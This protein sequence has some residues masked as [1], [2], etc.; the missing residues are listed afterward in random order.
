M[1]RKCNKEIG[2]SFETDFCALMFSN[3]FWAHNF[4]CNHSGQPADI[5]SCKNGKAILV[6]CKDCKSNNF[7]TSRIE[8]NQIS[9]MSLWEQCG[10]GQGWFA[11]RFNDGSIHMASL[12]DL[13]KYP[14]RLK[15]EFSTDEILKISV[16]FEDWIKS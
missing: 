12:E 5:I 16:P 1:K 2:N 11:L 13:L 14:T 15:G 9:S 7:K 4:A 6:D 8:T 10:N 3:G